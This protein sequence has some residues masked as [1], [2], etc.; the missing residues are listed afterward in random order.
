M[1]LFTK[2]IVGSSVFGALRRTYECKATALSPTK[3]IYLTRKVVYDH[4]VPEPGLA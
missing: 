2:K 4:F 1:F 3:I